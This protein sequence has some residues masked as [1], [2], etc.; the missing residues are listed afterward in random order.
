MTEDDIHVVPY[1]RE[2]A[3]SIS[4]NLFEGVPEEVV[5]SQRAELLSP[6][7]E[8]VF[9]VCAIH[10]NE[11]IGVCT[12][13]RMRWAGSRHRIEMV[14]VVVNENFRGRG[15]A[16]LMM[17][18]ISEHFSSL[19]IEIVQISAES[20]NTRAIT[21]YERIGFRRFGVLKEGIKHDGQYADEIMM[22]MSNQDFLE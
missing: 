10:E 14:Q 19:E 20:T 3:K 4:E 11:V 21:A 8:E 9:S 12:G 2:H 15:V 18:R 7:P 16:R 6:G 17:Q 13:V 1:S 5:L 22:A